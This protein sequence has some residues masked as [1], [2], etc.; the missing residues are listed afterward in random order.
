MSVGE[1]DSSLHTEDLKF[2]TVVDVG[3]PDETFVWQYAPSDHRVV[4]SGG[5]AE[6]VGSAGHAR[7]AT[8]ANAPAAR[9][10]TQ[11]SSGLSGPMKV[12][13]PTSFCGVRKT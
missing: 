8:R 5:I 7:H 9:I 6:A 4:A 13:K 2:L 12:A 1:G 10:E 3:P 11:L